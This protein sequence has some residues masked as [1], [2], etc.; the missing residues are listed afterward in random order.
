MKDQNFL[1]PCGL[2]CGICSDL[3]VNHE[4]KGCGVE[5]G[6]GECA[7]C[8]HHAHCRIYQCV[9]GKGYLTCAECDD[10]P[11]T[12][13]IEFAYD[14]FWRSHLPVIENLRRIRKIGAEAWLAEQAEY[15]S[16]DERRLRQEYAKAEYGARYQA[17]HQKKKSFIS[18]DPTGKK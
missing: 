11:C 15:W 2:Y 8:W 12:M 16:D 14:P 18:S 17:Y 6:C 5:C 9:R 7:A 1:A 4:C 13:L 3:T 10:L